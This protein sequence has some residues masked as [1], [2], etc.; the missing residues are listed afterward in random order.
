MTLLLAIDALVNQPDIYIP[1][2]VAGLTVLGLALE[3]LFRLGR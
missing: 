1:P 2:L 3:P